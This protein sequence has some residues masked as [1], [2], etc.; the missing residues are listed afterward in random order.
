MFILISG[1]I[2]YIFSEKILSIWIG[3]E[4]ATMHSGLFKLLILP[5]SISALGVI[6]YYYLN[7]TGH[8]KLNT[9]IS[10]L[11]SISIIITYCI[12]I[13]YTGINGAAY[14]RY[15]GIPLVIYTFYFI[16]KNQ[17]RTKRS[18]S[19]ALLNEKV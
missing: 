16:V 18:I 1:G 10:L 7:G 3:Y 19:N 15:V 8:V 4:F 12:I 6:P 14:G 9:V 17:Y 2:C 5:V 11:S 13:P